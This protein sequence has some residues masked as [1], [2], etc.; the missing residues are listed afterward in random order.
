MVESRRVFASS[1]RGRRSFLLTLLGALAVLLSATSLA[2]ALGELTQ[3]SGTAGCISQDGTEGACAT[4]KALKEPTDLAMSPDGRS[5]YVTSW[6]SDAVAIFDRDLATGALAQKP[7]TAGCISDRV[8]KGVCQNGRALMQPEGVAVSP[9]GKSVYVISSCLAFFRNCRSNAVAIF[10]RDP[11]TGAL[12]QKPGTAGCISEGGTK[13]TCRNGEAL[14]E[15]EGV[16]VSPDGKSVYVVGGCVVVFKKCASDA[17]AIFDRDPATGA[18]TQRDGSAGCV[19]EGGKKDACRKGRGLLAPDAVAVSPD[20]QS[21]YVTS[22]GSDSVAIFDRNPAT[23]ALAQK[24]G[25]AG[26]VAGGA[27]KS[28]CRK[29]KTLNDPTDVA[30]STDGKSVYVASVLTN[31]VAIFDRNPAT[32]ALTQKAGRSGCISGGATGGACEHDEALQSPTDVAVS[33]DGDSVYVVTDCV[34]LERCKSNAMS[35]LDRDPATGA[36]RQKPGAAGC[37]SEGGA[38]GAC[39]SA[40]AFAEPAGVAVSPDGMSVYVASS[41]RIIVRGCRSNAVEIFDREPATG[42]LRQSGNR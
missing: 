12:T 17:V 16:A 40:R 38:K 7:D 42:A 41:C 27:A 18:L 4:G 20:G 30:V 22:T 2:W 29:G 37:V 3:K 32:G 15:P 11:A 35:I 28:R 6:G 8:A 33:P 10:D 25:S 21:V 14:D 39:Q 13:G 5:V 19:S 34:F 23:G 9:D 36:L 31:A 24:H 1:R 26:C